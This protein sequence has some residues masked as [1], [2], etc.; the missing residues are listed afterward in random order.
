MKEETGPGKER[1]GFHTTHWSVVLAAGNQRRPDADAALDALCRTYWYPLYAHARRSGRPPE[2]AQDLVQEF[3]AHLFTR[4]GLAEAHP[5]KG[6]F[7]SFLLANR[8][9]RGGGMNFFSFDA[10]PAEERYRLEP[11]DDASPDRLFERGWA[12]SILDRTLSILQEECAANGQLTRFEALRDHLFG[13]PSSASYAAVAERL[14]MTVAG[15]TSAL[16]RLRVRFR[17]VFRSVI[18]ETVA[19]PED[20]D[21]EIRYL[22]GILEP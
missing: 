5:E 10:V 18:R 8:L 13:D 1:A 17:Q 12:R 20:I 4:D 11:L 15:V 16:F 3:F 19:N 14:G 21:D 9:K 22:A 6:R 7:R 2:E